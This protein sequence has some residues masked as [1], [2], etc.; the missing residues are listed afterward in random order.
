MTIGLLRTRRLYHS[1]TTLLLTLG[2][3][4][5]TIYLYMQQRFTSIPASVHGPTKTPNI[6]EIVS[7]V[8]SKGQVTVPAEVRKHLGIGGGDKLSFVIEDEGMVRVEAPRYQDVASLRGAAGSLETPL[9][10]EEMR[11]IAREDRV[12][13]VDEVTSS[14]DGSD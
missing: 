2:R 7:T 10:W 3:A 9:T 12:R 8:S 4:S 13:K 6:G 14:E 11:Q 5:A 1:P